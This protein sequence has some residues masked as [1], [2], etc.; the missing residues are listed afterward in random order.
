MPGVMALSKDDHR[1]LE[2][3]FTKLETAEPADTPPL[4]L[5]NLLA[6]DPEA[7]SVDG[8]IAARARPWS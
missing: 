5:T 3:V 1:K 4:T 2:A 7:P 8:L 6:A